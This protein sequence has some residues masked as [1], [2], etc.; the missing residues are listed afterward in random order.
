MG[1]AALLVAGI[2]FFGGGKFFSEV[3]SG[4]LYFDEP[5]TGLNVGSPVQFMGVKIGEVTDIQLLV[6][7]ETLEFQ[8]KVVFDFYR[9]TIVATDPQGRPLWTD[10]LEY[11]ILYS[12]RSQSH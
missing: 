11:A 6:N 3:R 10:T 4:V 12:D 8:T 2:L 9:D 5:V 1:A 7:N